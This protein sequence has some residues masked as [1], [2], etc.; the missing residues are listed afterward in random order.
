MRPS[1]VRYWA[2]YIA[3]TQY[4]SVEWK[5]VILL[6]FHPIIIVYTTV[7]FMSHW[8]LLLITYYVRSYR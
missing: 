1:R 3:V 2:V 8:L 4:I 6:L 7:M 5:V